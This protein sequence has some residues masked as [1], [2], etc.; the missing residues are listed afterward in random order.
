VRDAFDRAE[1]ILG[2]FDRWYRIAGYP[3]R[4]RFAGTAMASLITPALEHLR[5]DAVLCPALTVCVWDV[6]STRPRV[7]A[8]P[9]RVE[10]DAITAAPP[11]YRD[12]R[13]RVTLDV[14]AGALS[15][16]DCAERR[17]WYCARDAAALPGWEFGAPFRLI[18]HWALGARGR[19]LV[20]AAAVGRPDGGVL[21]VGMGGAGKST[22]ALSCLGTELRY[23]ADDYCMLS[24]D[25]EPYAHSLYNSAK[26]YAADLPQFPRL[27]GIH[28]RLDAPGMDKALLY[29]YPQ[30]ADCI[31]RGFPI[32]AIVVPSI[33]GSADT[34]ARPL[35]PAAA[36]RALAPSTML[37]VIG[38]DPATLG[39]L[40]AYVK[41]V[42]CYT[43]RLGSA[44]A[45]IPTAIADVLARAPGRT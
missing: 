15:V 30:A 9:W 35:S 36:L 17:A 11:R 8:P 37:Q 10:G 33:S 21:L 45:R 34:I 7:P 1:R 18:L 6:E 40:A 27:A 23:A 25:P 12:E 4:L 32:R 28:R 26:V 16:L 22:T 29:L 24:A 2:P 42:P 38:P 13:V 14:G 41:R 44:R 39:V 3:V 31:A 5:T 43:L 19:Q 20:H